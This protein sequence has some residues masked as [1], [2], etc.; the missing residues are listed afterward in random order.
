MEEEREREKKIK[1]EESAEEEEPPE[2]KKSE[3]ISR[4][5]LFLFWRAVVMPVMLVV[6]GRS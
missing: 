1:E 2:R 5:S 6:R 3:S 4:L